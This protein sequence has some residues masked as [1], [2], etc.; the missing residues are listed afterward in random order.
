MSVVN[1]VFKCVKITL[2]FTNS[3]ISEKRTTSLLP[4]WIKL[5]CLCKLSWVFERESSSAES[6]KKD[7]CN[8]YVIYI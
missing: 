6:M 7:A 8:L 3:T 4:N 1:S 2:S 5:M